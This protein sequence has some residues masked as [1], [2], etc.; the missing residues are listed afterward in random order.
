MVAPFAPI[1]TFSSSSGSHTC[2]ISWT[3]TPG[4]LSGFPCLWCHQYNIHVKYCWV[5]QASQD[6][7]HQPKEISKS[8]L[9]SEGNVVKLKQLSW[10]YKGCIFLWCL[11][12]RHLIKSRKMVNGTEEWSNGQQSPWDPGWKSEDTEG[13]SDQSGL[14]ASDDV[15]QVRSC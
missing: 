12:H 2:P 3:P 13:R 14:I 9:Q 15:R 6:N 8:I 5:K 7:L 4:V 10:G 1:Y 11:L